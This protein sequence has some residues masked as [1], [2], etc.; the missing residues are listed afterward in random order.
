M[1]ALLRIGVFSAAL[2]GTVLSG[3]ILLGT[4]G[5][6]APPSEGKPEKPTTPEAAA[7]E[8]LSEKGIRVSHAGLSLVDEKELARALN[9]ANTLKRKLVTAAREQ[10][11][12]EGEIEDLQA[13]L[14]LRLQDSVAL[15]TQLTNVRNNPVAYN[16][17]VAEIN[18]NNGA[19]RL[20]DQQQQECKKNLDVVRKKA[21]GAQET[22]VAQIAEIRT[23]VD[24][25]S[26]RYKD[27]KEDADAQKALAEWNQAANTSLEIKPSSYF[28]SSIK[29][30]QVLEKTV[31]SEKIPLRREGNSYYATVVVNGKQPQEMVV[32]TGASSVVLP[33]NVAMECGVKPDDSSIPV[34]ATIADGSKVK[35]KLVTLDSVRIGKFKAEKVECAVLPEGAKNAPTLLGMTYLS[36]FKFSIDGTELVLSQIVDD[37]ASPKPK[38]ARATKSTR[39]PRKIEAQQAPSE[40]G[41]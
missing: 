37:H 26:Q 40:P 9:E 32:D 14:R 12:A 35:A 39:K 21:N 2:F 18:A 41:S 1:A 4:R 33:Y 23:L 27:L 7:R 28:L 17:I 15:N 34:E 10:Q 8:K 5:V 11:G 29:K 24:K 20:I 6:A 16:Q 30:L 3:P 36:R 31:D 25:L 19:M 38:K 22:Y 13:A